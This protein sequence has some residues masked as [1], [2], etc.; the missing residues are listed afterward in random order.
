[1]LKKLIRT[2]RAGLIDRKTIIGILNFY[3]DSLKA[4]SDKVHLSREQVEIL[5]RETYQVAK[6]RYGHNKSNAELFSLCRPL[7]TLKKHLESFDRIYK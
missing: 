6:E 7:L 4:H 3:L 1:M 2:I 5:Y